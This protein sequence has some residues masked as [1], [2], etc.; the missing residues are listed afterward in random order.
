MT[1]MH[2]KAESQGCAIADIQQPQVQRMHS[3]EA[4]QSM[5]ETSDSK[6]WT[7]VGVMVNSH[8]DNLQKKGENSINASPFEIVEC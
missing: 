1:V 7:S 8:D 4:N 2:H 6:I 5:M 3:A